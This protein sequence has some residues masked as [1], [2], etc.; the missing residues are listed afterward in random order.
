MDKKRNRN[1]LRSKRLIR[2]AFVELLREK[3]FEKITVKELVERADINRSTFYAHYPDIMGILEEIECEIIEYVENSMC[4]IE[5]DVFFENPEPYIKAVI[6][7][8][9]ENRELYALLSKSEI[10]SKYLNKLKEVIYERIVEEAG[11]YTSNKENDMFYCRFFIGGVIEVC[12]Q[13]VCGTI[14][15][16]LDAMVEKLVKWVEVAKSLS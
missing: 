7:L 9:V 8:M 14:D 1:A 3:T 5:A 2:Q 4:R 11:E 10:T 13:W 12:S 15:Y 16:S 6:A